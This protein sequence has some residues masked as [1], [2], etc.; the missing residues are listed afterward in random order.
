MAREVIMGCCV[1]DILAGNRGGAIEGLTMPLSPGGQ[2]E[3]WVR[4]VRGCKGDEGGGIWGVIDMA[5]LVSLM[6]LTAIDWLGR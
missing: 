4:G 3:A 1:S 2:E 5:H 6:V